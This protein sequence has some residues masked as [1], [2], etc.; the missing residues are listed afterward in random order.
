MDA[1]LFDGVLQRDGVDDGREHAHVVGGDAVHMDGLF[2]DAAKEVAAANNDA[3]LA[4]G[5]CCIR[6]LVGDCIDKYRIYTKTAASGQSF[7][8]EL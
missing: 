5:A 4:A 8:G 1:G 2:G 6:D 7:S 3:D